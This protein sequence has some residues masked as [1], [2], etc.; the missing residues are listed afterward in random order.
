M[1]YTGVLNWR[2]D[3]DGLIALSARFPSGSVVLVGPTQIASCSHHC[4]ALP[5]VHVHPP[6]DRGAVAGIVFGADLGIIAHRR[7]ALTEAM[8]PLKL[9]EYLAAGKPVATPDLGP[10]HDI[11]PRVIVSP[12]PGAWPTRRRRR[13]HYL[14]WM[15]RRVSASSSATRGGA[16]INSFRSCAR[17]SPMTVSETTLDA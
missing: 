4:E 1:L 6:V 10:V 17:L 7:S 3:I 9:Y 11:D 5:N 13:S 15:R 2:L 8:S 12:K 14:R 16:V